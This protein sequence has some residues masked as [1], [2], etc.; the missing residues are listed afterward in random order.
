LLFSRALNWQVWQAG[1][2]FVFSM[3]FD[4]EKPLAARL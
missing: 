3:Q 4:S 2:L 1:F